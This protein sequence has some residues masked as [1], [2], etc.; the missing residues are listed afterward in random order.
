MTKH[1]APENRPKKA[2]K[3]FALDAGLYLHIPYCKR[4]CSY[5]NFHF[6]TNFQTFND[7]IK[8][9]LQEMNERCE[10]A[11]N[12]HI[13][14]IYFGGGTP[15]LLSAKELHLIF[16]QLYKLFYIDAQAEI[17]L[18]AN[19][20]DISPEKV[21]LWK[22]LGI[23]RLSVGIQSFLQEDLDWMN[24]VH[25]AEQ[26]HHSLKTL[27]N[28]E[29]NNITI[30]LMYGLPGSNTHRLQYNLDQIIHYELPHFSA[31]AL[32]IEERTAIK[33]WTGTGKIEI[34]ADLNT[35][36]QMYQIL[37]FCDDFGYEAYE[38]S[39]FAK[40][41]FRS[42]HNSAYWQR[43]PYLGFGPSA[44]SFDGS[45]R[46]WNISNNALYIQK[47]NNGQPYFEIE[48]L[49][50]INRYN[51]YVMLNLRRS[52]GIDLKE[53]KELFPQF[54]VHFNKEVKKF[55]ATQDLVQNTDHYKFSRK[56]KV[57]ADQITA[58]LFKE[59]EL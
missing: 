4:K 57:L 3:S 6:S 14:T 27:L 48:M 46:R 18:E 8:G 1:I 55:L 47:L 50:D 26:S 9:L 22:Q 45:K 38:I 40:R 49:S 36:D 32:T 51:E 43:K 5:C 20:E 16:D 31:Y 29:I 58:S 41:G 11:Q 59:T 28:S 10:E 37:D 52:E 21:L 56:G 2:I 7:L 33:H 23:N 42:R 53:L 35:V 44:H 12:Y 17:S 15:S 34:P 19:P 13:Q 30:D 25:K 24:R 39:N 54:I